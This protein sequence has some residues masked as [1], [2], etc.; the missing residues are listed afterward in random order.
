MLPNF[1]WIDE[2]TVGGMARPLPSLYEPMCDA[3][4]R[5]VVTLTET[6]LVGDPADAGLDV[7]HDPI[8]DFHPPTQEQLVRIVQWMRERRD[9]GKPVVVHCMAGIG[10]TGTILAAWLVAEGHTAIHAISTI[11]EL[12]AGSIETAAQ[13]DAVAQFERTWSLHVEAEG[14]A[15]RGDDAQRE[16][17]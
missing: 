8:R 4:I 6:P 11:R 1:S 9:A 17:D 5:A 14:A 2:G 7:L 10:R 13:E 16:D 12:R 3:G 15:Q